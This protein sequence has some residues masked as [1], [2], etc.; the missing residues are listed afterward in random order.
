MC[1]SD[2]ESDGSCA[3]GDL[4]EMKRANLHDNVNLLIETGGSTR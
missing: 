3:T 1:G 4:D 2:L